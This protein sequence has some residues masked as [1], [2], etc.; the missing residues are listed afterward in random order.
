MIKV[1][2]HLSGL[3]F[4]TLFDSLGEGGIW[5]KR[6]VELSGMTF[7]QE[8]N[9]NP[10]NSISYGG[11]T[12]GIWVE[13]C[14]MQRAK[15]LVS[16]K[17][18]KNIDYLFIE[19]INDINYVNNGKIEGNINDDPWFHTKNIDILTDGVKSREEVSSIWD[20]KFDSIVASIPESERELGSVILIPYEQPDNAEKLTILSSP[21]KDGAIGVLIGSKEFV[22]NV[23]AGQSIKSIVDK[24]VQ[25]SYGPGWR[26]IKISENSVVFA[27]YTDTTEKLSLN[28][29][30][31]GIGFSIG[32]CQAVGQ[33]SMCFTGSNTDREWNDKR[34][35]NSKVSLY[36]QYKG[37]LEYIMTSLPET[38]IFWFIPT[39]FGED[40]DELPL[41]S[42]GTID[43][44]TF[45][46]GMR[47]QNINALFDCQKAVARLYNIPI[48]DIEKESG[49]NIYNVSNFYYSKDVHPKKEGYYRWA[50]T[51]FRLIN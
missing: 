46:N 40:F 17:N 1:E 32:K 36:S 37:L 28:A 14:G 15:N 49:I 47:R 11:T 35:W 4:F 8:Q 31:T 20:N 42:N 33:F 2:S 26:D 34:N 13:T 16:L 41:R 29:R 38:K 51:I 12:T 18:T 27:Y 7:D 39:F 9:F 5:Q 50:E 24:I 23:Q 6:L 43:I 30:D 3:E 21:V 44:E 22:I 25:C 48:L 19:N 45:N 10:W